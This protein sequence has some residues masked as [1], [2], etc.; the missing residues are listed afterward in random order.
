MNEV[1]ISALVSALAYFAARTID[2]SQERIKALEERLRAAETEVA[3]TA[4]VHDH[5]GSDLASLRNEIRDLRDAIQ[6]LA[7]AMAR[8]SGE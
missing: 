1:L 7:V 4:Q 2:G 3:R 5:L 6:G 8:A